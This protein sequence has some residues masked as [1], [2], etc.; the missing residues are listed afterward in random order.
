MYGDAGNDQI[1]ASTHLTGS[2]Y[3]PEEGGNNSDRLYGGGGDDTYK[4]QERHDVVIEKPGQGYDTVIVNNSSTGSYTLSPN[5]EQVEVWDWYSHLPCDLTGNNQPNFIL[6]TAAENTLNGKGGNDTLYGDAGTDLLIGG[7]G[8]DAIYGDAG[9]DTIRG[10]AGLDRLFGSDGGDRFDYDA[11]SDSRRGEA[12]RD[13]IHDYAG[14]GGSART[15]VI[16]LSTIDA[17]S[18]A[19]GNQAFSFRGTRAFSAPGQIRVEDSGWDTLIQANVT[20]TSGAEM[21]ILVTDGYG[22]ASEWNALDFLL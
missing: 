16:D 5:V 6:G 15:D 21:E 2:S 22:P 11:V 14:V 10:G 1:N 12:S 4:V 9:D 17:N 8:G 13:V 7:N 18:S 20:G 19:G 3:M